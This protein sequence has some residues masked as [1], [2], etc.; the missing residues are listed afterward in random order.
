MEYNK[1][2]SITGKSGLYETVSSKTDGA[3]VKSLDNGNTEFISSRLHNF[4]HLESIEVYTTTDNVNLVEVLTAMQNSKE[5]RPSDKDDKAVLA[6]FTKV[7]PTID[8]DRV[9]KSDMKKMVKWLAIL[10]KNNVALT[11]PTTDD[12]ATDSPKETVKE[13][14]VAKPKASTPKAA[15]LKKAPAKTITSPRKMA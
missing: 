14:V 10:E 1:L 6:Y 9:Y 3:V 4:S 12:E 8:T 5:P 13:A 7:Y 11:L 2:I 15:P